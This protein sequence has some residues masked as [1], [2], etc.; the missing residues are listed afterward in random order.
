MYQG[1]VY[2]SSFAHSLLSRLCIHVHSISQQL[3]KQL[4]IS[5]GSNAVCNCL[6]SGGGHVLEMCTQSLWYWIFNLSDLLILLLPWSVV[7]AALCG[8]PT[9]LTCP[10]QLMSSVWCCAVWHYH[11]KAVKFP[12][13]IIV[14]ISRCYGCVHRHTCIVK[15][16]RI[17]PVMYNRM[18]S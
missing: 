1:N 11:D 12:S 8:G 5:T 18:Q 2:K 13:F 17:Q 14:I 16:A 15:V 9:S 7:V 4:C 3:L 10:V 6:L